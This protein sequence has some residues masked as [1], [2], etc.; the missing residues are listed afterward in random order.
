MK[1]IGITGGVGAGKSAIL[2]YLKEKHHAVVVE[3]DKVGHLLMEPGGACYYSIV[4]KFGSSI[5]N[6]DQTINRGKLGKI[7]FAD[8]SLL[9]EL[10]KIIHPR[11]KS[12]IVSEIAKERAYHRTN[13][14]VVEAA[15][16][17]EDHYDVICDEM[18]YIHTDADIRAKRLKET[19]GYD[20]EKIAGI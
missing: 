8:E 9:N 12:H 16:L 15:L 17:I 11:V 13:Y 3:A 19:R 10:N 6:G 4:E 18:W 2:N 20:D 1:V 14:F 7:V 5:L